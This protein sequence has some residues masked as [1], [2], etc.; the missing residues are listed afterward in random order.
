A[1]YLA[2]H[3]AAS[4]SAGDLEIM[5]RRAARYFEL[6]G[7]KIEALQHAVEAGDDDLIVNIVR[8]SGGAGVFWVSRD[9][10]TAQRAMDRLQRKFPEKALRL[11]PVYTFFMGRSGR[12]EEARRNVGEGR[13]MLE[14]LGDEI[15][16]SERETIRADLILID[17][18]IALYTYEEENLEWLV[19]ELERIRYRGV[20]ADPVYLGIVHNMLGLVQFRMGEMQA[21]AQLFEDAGGH[22]ERAG[23]YWSVVYSSIHQSCVM[24]ESGEAHEAAT[25]VQ[26][27]Y[28]LFR[29][30]ARQDDALGEKVD[31]MAARLQ[32]L[33]AASP[34]D[35]IAA[36]QLLADALPRIVANGEYWAELLIEAYRSK[37][38]LA[39]ANYGLAGAMET[40]AHGIGLARS[41]GIE[42]LVQG[43]TGMQIRIASLAGDPA[44]AERLAE[45]IGADFDALNFAPPG[46]GWQNDAE[47]AFG[48]I[49][50]DIA[51]GDAR[52]ALER[53]GRVER[54][55]DGAGLHLTALKCAVLRCL[56]LFEARQ[57]AEAAAKLRQILPVLNNGYRA[58]LLEEGALARQ[59]LDDAASR[60][61]RSVE[62]DALLLAAVEMRSLAHAFMPPEV[63]AEPK[64]PTGPAMEV[65]RRI[66]EGRRPKDIAPELEITVDGVNHH[67]KSMRKKMGV[68]S[69]PAL[70]AEAIRMGFLEDV[71]LAPKY[72]D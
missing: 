53:I 65:L 23:S 15:S 37:A 3:L 46:F 33:A 43:L 39:Y 52:Q 14:R 49:R 24:L 48:L 60:I 17:A 67:L 32:Y 41:R 55:A 66:A 70:V 47:I 58:I 35:L 50:L 25:A 62:R 29:Q 54:A 10:E 19:S 21:T 40:L 72:R 22:Y 28:L 44:L 42:R 59:M 45:D 61:A 36:R 26:R 8:D 38:A 11:L 57:E 6:H 69:T 51:R 56:A 31:V 63:A 5:H 2:S 4:R 30:H 13:R 64:A 34:K 68:T 12:L 7:E 27:A 16:E 18:T 20:S 71:A 1:D 9:F